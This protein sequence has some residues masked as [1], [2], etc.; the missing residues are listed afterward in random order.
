MKISL[1]HPAGEP[2][3]QPL[4]VHHLARRL[5]RL[6]LHVGNEIERVMVATVHAPLGNELVGLGAPDKAL[7]HQSGE[8]LAESQPVFVHRFGG[9]LQVIP[10]L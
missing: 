8:D 1:P 6:P 2:L 5:G 4:Q 7:V 10:L 3:G 9:K